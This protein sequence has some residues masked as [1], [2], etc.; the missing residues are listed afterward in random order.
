MLNK[1][2]ADFFVLLTVIRPHCWSVIQP[3]PPQHEERSFTG[4]ATLQ[5]LED[6][7][8]FEGGRVF[9]QPG[10]MDYWDDLGPDDD[11]DINI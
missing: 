6:I 8:S 5:V 4:P 1:F 9:Y 2:C 3:H 11:L 10:D 7:K